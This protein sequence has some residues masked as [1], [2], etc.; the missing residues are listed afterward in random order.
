[1][2]LILKAARF[3]EQAHRRA[4]HFRKHTGE[5][6][7]VHP[8]RVAARVTI[9][10][11]ATEEWVAAAWLHDTLEDTKAT[12]HD[13]LS[14]FGPNILDLVVEL[15][16]PSKEWGH[17]PRR[18]RKEI[19][20]AHLARVS[21]PA[22]IIKMADRID[23]L[24]DFHMQGQYEFLKDCYLRESK[25]VL[26]VVEDSDLGLATELKLLIEFLEGLVNGCN[27]RHQREEE[28]EGS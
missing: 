20:R 18:Q 1:M 6:Y 28:G 2:S 5:P 14:A 22:K 15:T 27:C 3:A 16:N 19:D 7:I 17:L 24:R 10:P 11:D 21:R 25:G 12:E 26:D 13:T 8:G 4:N 23:N 9:H